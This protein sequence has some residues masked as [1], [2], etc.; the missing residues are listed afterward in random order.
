MQSRGGTRC[1]RPRWIPAC[2]ACTASRAL[3]ARQVHIAKH[4]VQCSCTVCGSCTAPAHASVSVPASPKIDRHICVCSDR[5]LGNNH[6]GCGGT[7]YTSW[8]PMHELRCLDKYAR[9]FSSLRQLRR[10][11]PL[12]H[13][14]V[15]KRLT[16]VSMLS[17]SIVRVWGALESVLVRS[18]SILSKSDRTMRIVRVNAGEATS[19]IGASLWPST[20]S[21]VCAQCEGI[22]IGRGCQESAQSSILS[23]QSFIK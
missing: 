23:A 18:E 14:Q 1:T 8:G 11:H 3:T 13:A 5:G 16:K 19:L 4:M 22:I 10:R 7:R 20:L 15:G 17:G 9:S 12:Q 21:S 6:Q 2:T